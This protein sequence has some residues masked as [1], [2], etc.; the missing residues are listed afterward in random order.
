MCTVVVGAVND[1]CFDNFLEYLPNQGEDVMANIDLGA[2]FK[3]RRRCM[4]VSNMGGCGL[5]FLG[6]LT[7]AAASSSSSDFLLMED[8]S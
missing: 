4:V 8:V 2:N 6:G 1:C 7:T 5:L 3:K